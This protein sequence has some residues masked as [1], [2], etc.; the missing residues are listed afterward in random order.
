MM[1]ST[2]QMRK[3]HF[4]DVLIIKHVSDS[5][6]FSIKKEVSDQVDLTY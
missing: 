2:I 1:L 6:K 4:H 5:F 3:M